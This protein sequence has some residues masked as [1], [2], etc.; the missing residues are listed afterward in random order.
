MLSL[1]VPALAEEEEGSLGHDP[2]NIIGLLDAGPADLLGPAGQV[3]SGQAWLMAEGLDP[4][5]GGMPAFDPYTGTDLGSGGNRT[6]AAGAGAP[7]PFREPGPAFSRNILVTR[8]FGSSPFQT[9]PH[10]EANPGDPEHLV[11]GVIDYAFPAMSS[12]V[13]FDGGERWEGPFPEEW[14]RIS[15]PPS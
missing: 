14:E 5:Q 6:Q 12:Y 11:L 8:D 13:S 7:V 4:G 10:I 15:V 9:E 3:L 2:S 1:S